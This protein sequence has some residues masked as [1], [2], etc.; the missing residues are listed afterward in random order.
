[1]L[2]VCACSGCL[3]RCF[4]PV[5]CLKVGPLPPSM[6]REQVQKDAGG[7]A[8]LYAESWQQV[9]PVRMVLAR[10]E[11]FCYSQMY[12][13]RSSL[14]LFPSGLS[15]SLNLGGQDGHSEVDAD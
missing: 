1:M 5:N 7:D 9:L 11:V 12:V 15:R 13:K 8:V 10:Y 14:F 6:H 4:S 3:N 2:T